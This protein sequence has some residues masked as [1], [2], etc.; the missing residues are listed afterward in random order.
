MWKP[1]QQLRK[2]QKLSAIE[3]LQ[4]IQSKLAWLQKLTMAEDED[5]DNSSSSD[6]HQHHNNNF[7][8]K[9][10]SKEEEKETTFPEELEKKLQLVSQLAFLQEHVIAHIERLHQ[11]SVQLER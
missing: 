8:K 4:S 3:Q 2:Q 1:Q 7:Y 10:T 5:E 9:F 6:H 11:C